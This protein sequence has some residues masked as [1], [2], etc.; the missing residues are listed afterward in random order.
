VVA[1]GP[2]SA[3]ARVPALVAVVT[4]RARFITESGPPPIS[5]ST[6]PTDV[7]A[8]CPVLTQ[9]L[10]LALRSVH[11]CLALLVASFS[12]PPGGA[13]TLPSNRVA[14]FPVLTIAPV[15]TTV[16]I[17]TQSAR[18][19]AVSS[20]V[21]G[22][23]LAG[24]VDGIA[25]PL[26]AVATVPALVSPPLF[27]TLVL[28]GVAYE[29][30]L[31]LALPVLLVAST[32][33]RTAASL[34]ALQSPRVIRTVFLAGRSGFSRSALTF[35]GYPVAQAAVRATAHFQAAHSPRARAANIS[36]V[37]TTES[38]WAVSLASSCD[39]IA[40]HPFLAS[41][42]LTALVSVRPLCAL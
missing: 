39:V 32:S 17:E 34:L 2:V 25:I 31:A 19:L 9:A 29:S 35:P 33:V 7:V 26:A 40:I 30:R 22:L 3:L 28:A 16:A 6:S 5:A 20:R 41:A 1:S 13:I 15:G 36:A 37:F 18:F 27:G 23:T 12:S 10:L 24:S 14:G 8:I 21:S 4:V 38:C 11:P 42:L